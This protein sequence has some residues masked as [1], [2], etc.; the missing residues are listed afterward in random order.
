MFAGDRRPHYER[1]S[2]VAADGVKAINLLDA[3]GETLLRLPVSNNTYGA[4]LSTA[5][6][7]VVQLQAVD[8]TGAVVATLPGDPPGTR[9]P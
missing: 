1:V 8:T 4:V 7:D 6:Y 2:G 3:A 5:G 9:R